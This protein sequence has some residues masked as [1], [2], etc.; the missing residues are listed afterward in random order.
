MP[1]PQDVRAQ[2][3]AALQTYCD[4]RA[5][6]FVR[7]DVRFEVVLRGDAATIYER[8]FLSSGDGGGVWSRLAV[9]QFR[10]DAGTRRWTLHWADRSSRWHVYDDLK[11][12]KKCEELIAEVDADPT[13][14]FWE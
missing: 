5:S 1:L 10:F 11:P 7:D 12:S 2:A 8:Q 14:I 3:E 9:A 13:G 6:V 4:L